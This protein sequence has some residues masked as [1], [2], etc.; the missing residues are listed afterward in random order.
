MMR[1]SSTRPIFSESLSAMAR[2]ERTD[3]LFSMIGLLPML[4]LLLLLLSATGGS[5]S[6]TSSIVLVDCNTCNNPGT[7]VL[8]CVNVCAWFCPSPWIKLLPP[9]RNEET[10]L[11]VPVG[12]T[13]ASTTIGCSVSR[14]KDC[15]I[16]KQDSVATIIVLLLPL[17]FV[18]LLLLLL[19][20]LCFAFGL[21]RKSIPFVFVLGIMVL[22]WMLLSVVFGFYTLLLNNTIQYNT[23]KYNVV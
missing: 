21:D 19:V 2:E 1:W 17:V 9:E 15:I 7:R 8:L 22:Q 14:N 3:F 6:I 10:D 20:L 16:T 12:D 11:Q 23:I 13:N 4:L 18:L 5:S